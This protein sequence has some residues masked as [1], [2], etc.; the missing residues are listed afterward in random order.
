[1]DGKRA[2]KR[3]YLYRIIDETGISGIGVIAEGVEFSNGVA[4]LSWVTTPGSTGMYNSTTDLLLI[5]G[6]GGKTII[7]WIDTDSPNDEVRQ[8]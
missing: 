1:M 2:M 3:F 8:D 6:H 7:E 4:I 5:H